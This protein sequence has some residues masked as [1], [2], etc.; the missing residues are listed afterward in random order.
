MRRIG[1]QAYTLEQIDLAQL[2]LQQAHI[3]TWQVPI[4]SQ[5]HA[6]TWLTAGLGWFGILGTLQTPI[7]IILFLGEFWDSKSPIHRNH[8]VIFESSTHITLWERNVACRKIT[9]NRYYMIFH[10]TC[11][12]SSGISQPAVFDYTRG[13][14]NLMATCNQF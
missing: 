7:V 5:G 2:T 1:R 11:S 14:V 13:Y 4:I 3:I 9:I 8:Q 12:F 10:Y 6:R